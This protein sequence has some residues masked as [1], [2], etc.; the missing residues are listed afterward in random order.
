MPIGI[1]INCASVFVGGMIG[2]LLQK[3]I[4][5]KMK[6]TL[7]TIFAFA[8]LSIGIVSLIKYDSLTI[9]II[10]VI[11][12]WILGEVV[13][14]ESKIRKLIEM[15]VKKNPKSISDKSNKFKLT[16]L[17]VVVAI[18]CFSGTGIFG[19]MLEGMNG[20]SSI[21]IAKSILDGLTALVFAASI[22]IIVAFISIP[23]LII[24][25]LLF[26]ISVLIEPIMI[27]ST[28]ANFIA[29]GGVVTI[30]LGFELLK[31]K[32]IR[33]MNTIPALLFVIIISYLTTLF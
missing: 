29:V 10:S 4:P 15:I 12:G 3:I 5:E 30:I 27:D 11:L 7:P 1:L 21:L 24:Y 18:F 26:L 25:I 22:G 20:D 17:T 28:V 6:E 13:N 2:T 14:I 31:I 8:A 23:Q 33:V 19:A 9:V 32:N 16:E